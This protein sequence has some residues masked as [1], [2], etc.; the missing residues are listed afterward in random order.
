MKGVEMLPQEARLKKNKEQKQKKKEAQS[1]N[2]K[3]WHRI[4]SVREVLTFWRECVGAFC[5]MPECRGRP[6][7]LKSINRV[8]PN[9]MNLIIPRRD[10]RW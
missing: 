10:Q 9:A 2:K 8:D 3:A 5:K 1:R 6:G 7:K 4:W